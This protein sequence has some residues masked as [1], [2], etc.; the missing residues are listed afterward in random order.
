MCDIRY[1]WGDPAVPDRCNS[2]FALISPRVYQK[3]CIDAVF[4][5]LPVQVILQGPRDSSSGTV[6]S[7]LPLRTWLILPPPYLHTA[8]NQKLKSVKAWEQGYKIMEPFRD[9]SRN[10]SLKRPWDCSSILGTFLKTR[11]YVPVIALW[12]K[13]RDTVARTRNDPAHTNNLFL[14]CLAFHSRQDFV[15]HIFLCV[16]Y[17]NKTTP[18]PQN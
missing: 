4:R 6:P 17:I 5:T 8:S 14:S 12:S 1:T 16:H 15:L 10:R 7:H 2:N 18:L 3:N 11:V 13:H 9:R